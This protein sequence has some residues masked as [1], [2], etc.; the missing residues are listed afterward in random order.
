MTDLLQDTLYHTAG[1]SS[2]FL[3]LSV[4]APCRSSSVCGLS[5][6]FISFTAE[7]VANAPKLEPSL[8]GLLLSANVLPQITSAFSVQQITSINLMVRLDSTEECFMKQVFG[9]DTESND[10]AHKREWAK[11][12]MVWQQAKLSCDTTERVDAVKR[13]HGE[14]VAFLTAD[15]T[16]LLREFKQQR[17]K[18]QDN[19]LPAQSYF[20]AFEESLQ[21]GS[22]QAETLSHVVSIAED[23]SRSE[24]SKAR[25]RVRRTKEAG[26]SSRSQR[27]RQRQRTQRQGEQRRSRQGQGTQ[28]QRGRQSSLRDGLWHE[29]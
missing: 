21:V 2:A 29:V 27:S 26:R 19:E 25:A 10:F 14:P 24:R 28:R 15:W 23:L 16:S 6:S 22:V 4:H 8:E 11:L 1:S 18:I 20:D 3:Q 13:A 12:N 9:I 7:E 5:M 17:G